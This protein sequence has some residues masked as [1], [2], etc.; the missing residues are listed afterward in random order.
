MDFSQFAKNIEP[1]D[2]MS[3]FALLPLKEKIEIYIDYLE[4]QGDHHFDYLF[5]GYEEEN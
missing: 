1:L 4:Y 3:W 5:R 2:L